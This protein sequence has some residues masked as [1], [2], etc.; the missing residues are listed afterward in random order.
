[1]FLSTGNRFGKGEVAGI[2]LYLVGILNP[3]PEFPVLSASITMDQAQIVWNFCERLSYRPRFQHW[4]DDIVTSP[5]PTIKLKTGTEIWARSTQHDCK[6]VEGHKFRYIN[7]DEIALGT[8]DSL[9]VLKMR[10]VDVNGTVGGT[11]TPRRK[12][13]YWRDCWRPAELEQA[14]AKKE[15][16][17]SKAFTLAGSSYDNPHISHK[18][19]DNLRLTDAQRQEKVDGMFVEGDG[20]FRVSA[21]EA[22]LDPNLNDQAEVYDRCGS[23]Q[24]GQ[25]TGTWVQGW[26]LA[27][28]ADWTVCCGLDVSTTPW[29]LR[30]FKRYQREPWPNTEADMKATQARFDADGLFDATG[31]GAVVEDHLDVPIWRFEPFQIK[32]KPVKVE[33]INNLVWCI[34][35]GKLKIPYIEQLVNELYDYEWDDKALV[36]DCVIALALACWKANEG[37]RPME[38]V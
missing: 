18:Y 23:G 27:K 15:G 36:Q 22:I 19:L 2:V 11:G 31:I 3:S 38:M 34:E 6:Y 10:V 25:P 4:V 33:L 9:D 35:Q 12:G 14:A 37:G 16:R 13:W 20:V 32:S 30:Y 26:D 17:K 7:F 29:E 5:F 28:A 8:R 21:I 1:M 24:D